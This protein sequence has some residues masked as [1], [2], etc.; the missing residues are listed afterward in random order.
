MFAE[1]AG[2]APGAGADGRVGIFETTSR[3]PR[4]DAMHRAGGSPRQ[5]L[6]GRTRAKESG[7]NS[8]ELICFQ[9]CKG[10]KES[11]TQ[12]RG[13]LGER[14]QSVESLSVAVLDRWHRG[15]KNRPRRRSPE[16]SLAKRPGIFSG[17]EHT[18]Q[19]RFKS[20][21]QAIEQIKLYVRSN[22]E[23]RASRMQNRCALN[24]L[25]KH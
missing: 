25:F 7:N 2:S 16:L 8:T 9:P 3:Q 6:S 19:M 12:R 17:D 18:I 22:S 23:S 21:V 1:L 5:P 14:E 20:I 13:C 4:G 15:R 11:T 24:M 10:G